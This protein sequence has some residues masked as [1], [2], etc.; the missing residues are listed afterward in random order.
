MPI[1]NKNGIISCAFTIPSQEDGG[2]ISHDKI[3]GKTKDNSEPN[4]WRYPNWPKTEVIIEHGVYGKILLILTQE[5][6]P[7]D[8]NIYSA[9]SKIWSQVLSLY[10]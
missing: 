3:P 8:I 2:N 9:T 7:N 10:C 5:D 1:L 4:K 6:V